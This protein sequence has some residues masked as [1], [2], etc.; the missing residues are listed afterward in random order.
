MIKN[1]AGNVAQVVECL[2]ISTKPWAQTPVYPKKMGGI[3]K[4]FH[5]DVIAD[6][7]SVIQRILLSH[8]L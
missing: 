6:L 3:N 5:T 1:Q 7:S 8:D 2:P 4:V